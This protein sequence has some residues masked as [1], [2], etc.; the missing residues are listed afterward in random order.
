MYIYIYIPGRDAVGN[1]TLP[2]LSLVSN[3]LLFDIDYIIM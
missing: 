1:A 3:G 2:K